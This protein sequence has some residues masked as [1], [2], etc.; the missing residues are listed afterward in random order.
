[1]IEDYRNTI[2]KVGIKLGLIMPERER[3]FKD[4]AVKEIE[5]QAQEIG[6]LKTALKDFK[7]AFECDFVLEDGTIVDRPDERWSPLV[8]L[9]HKSKAALAATGEEGTVN[10]HGAE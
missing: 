1:V 6:R 10:E 4:D 5:Q 3:Y 8:N 7:D 9:Y 2:I